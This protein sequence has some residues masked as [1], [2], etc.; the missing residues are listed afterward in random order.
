VHALG[1]R[2]PRLQALYRLDARTIVGHE[3]ITD[4]QHHDTQ[5][6]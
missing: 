1:Q 4:T 5:G 3:R 2:P 6:V